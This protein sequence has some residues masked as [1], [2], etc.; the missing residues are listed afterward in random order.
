MILQFLKKPFLLH[1]MQA[2]QGAM[3]EEIALQGQ[4]SFFGLRNDFWQILGLDTAYVDGDLADPQAQWVADTRNAVPHKQGILL[5]HHQP[6]SAFE[7]VS[8]KILDRLAPVLKQNL[9][10]AWWWGHEHRCAHYSPHNN[11]RHGRCIGYGGLPIVAD[12]MPNPDG[13]T[14][15]FQ[16]FVA[17][18]KPPFAHFG[19]AVFDF[20]ADK[21]HV[22]YLGEYGVPHIEEDIVAASGA[23]N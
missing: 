23:S 6:F 12:Q 16:D 20:D 1:H 2:L 22:Q 5:S 19:F 17:A 21:L 15:E 9:I 4:C 11:V 13:V 3:D 14:Y 10:L 8:T 18:S 7:T